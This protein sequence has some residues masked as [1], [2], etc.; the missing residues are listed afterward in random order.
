[1]KQKLIIYLI[2]TLITLGGFAQNKFE[3]LRIKIA[4]EKIDSLKV[5]HLMALSSEYLTENPDSALK[6]AKQAL[7]ISTKIDYHEGLCAGNQRIGVVLQNTGKYNEANKYFFKALQFAEKF[8][9]VKYKVQIFNSIANAFA[10]QKMFDQALLYYQNTLNLVDSTGYT[11]IK[12]TILMNMGNIAYNKGY[13]KKE[14]EKAYDYFNQALVLA[15]KRGDSSLLTSVYG[16]YA[17]VKTDDEKYDE[18]LYYIKKGIAI[19]EKLGDMDDKVYLN[20]YAGRANAHTKKFAEAIKHF[21]ASIKYAQ[22]L[23]DKDYLSENYLCLAELYNETKQHEKAYE[24]LWKYKLMEDSLL[25]DETTNQLNELKTIYETDK[26]EQEIELSHQK[27]QTQEGKLKNQQIIIFSSIG[28]AILLLVV[29]MVF[30]SRYQLKQKANKNLELAYNIIE[31]KNKDITDSINYA[32]KIQ[33]AILPNE[34]EIKTALKNYFVFFKPRDVVSGDF[35]WFHSLTTKNNE[36]LNF[37]AAAD[38]TGHGVPGAMMSMIG[39]SL[40]NQI[41][42]ENKIDSTGEVL[43]L[44]RSGIKAAFKQKAN[45][46]KRRDGMDIGLLAFSPNHNKL[47]FSGANNGLYQIRDGIL[48]EV[49]PDKQAIGENEGVETPFKTTIVE[50]QKNDCFYLFTD[51]FADQFGGEKGKK[52]KYA[53]LKELLISVSTLPM[54]QQKIKIEQVFTDWKGNIEQV[55]DVLLIG[56]KV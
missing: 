40:L 37:I 38:C 15:E 22:L 34:E 54:E 47:Q 10:Y 9:A 11:A 48:T 19:S 42:L 46:S 26:K 25:N 44:L 51:G 55:D 1:M 30:Y 49:K 12:G 35:Y 29:A 39:S 41:V 31:E 13:E 52:F 33:E 2:F 43:D 53:K 16:N 32:Q 17:L 21:N 18:A 50:T 24:Y 6:Y 27:L 8:N 7:E 3:Q 45:E 56:W 28:G 20:Y 23:D 36:P 14:F 5:N 4:K